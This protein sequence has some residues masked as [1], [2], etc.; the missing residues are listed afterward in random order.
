MITA[1]SS[2]IWK[3]LIPVWAR[4]NLTGVGLLVSP[5]ALD[6]SEVA[7]VEL[8]KVSAFAGCWAPDTP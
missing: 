3:L 7:L 4:V 1:P 2:N 5:C 8:S 6:G